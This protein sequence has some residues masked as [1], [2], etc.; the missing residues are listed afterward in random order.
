MITCQFCKKKQHQDHYPSCFSC[1]RLADEAKAKKE[2]KIKCECGKSFYDPKLYDSC[3]LCSVAKTY[4]QN[5]K[6]YGR[7]LAKAMTF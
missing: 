5:E 7:D 1:R 6:R 4:A 2:G 3:Y